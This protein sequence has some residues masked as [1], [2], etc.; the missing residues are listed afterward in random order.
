[1]IF[2]RLFYFQAA[3]HRH[4]S[5]HLP[6]SDERA[7]LPPH[8]GAQCGVT[9]QE[10]SMYY[11]LQHNNA[12]SVRS[13]S[14]ASK[15]AGSLAAVLIVIGDLNNSIVDN[16]TNLRVEWRQQRYINLYKDYI[17]IISK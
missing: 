5:L 8:A 15:K 4:H 1:M 6:V 2:K 3:V 7:D 12:S 13:K 9:Y 11:L 17:G 16:K 14:A 10:F